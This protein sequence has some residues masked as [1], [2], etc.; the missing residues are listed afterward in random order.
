MINFKADVLPLKNRLYR[1]ALRITLHTGE[2]EDIVQETM[3]KVWAHRAELSGPQSAEAYSMTV[4]RNMALDYLARKE[5]RHAALDDAAHEQADNAASPFQQMARQDG[6]MWVGRLFDQLPEKQR[7]VMQ[8]R[9]IEGKP[10]KEIAAILGITEDQV[11]VTLFRARQRIK[12]QFEK[13]S[14]Y[15]L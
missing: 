6:L 11:K 1:L 9:D 8:L 13:I 10:Y 3:I 2:A 14:R 7:T 15:G 5:S 4:C 12:E